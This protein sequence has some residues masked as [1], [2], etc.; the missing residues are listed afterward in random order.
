MKIL[1]AEPLAE[2]A[3][4][5]F[6]AEAGWNVVVSNPKEYASHLADCDAL[7]VRSAVKV[8]AE[9]LAQAPLLR[10]IGRAGVG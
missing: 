3:V 2:G 6:Q 5:L 1:I 9:V 8:T 7:V 4:S 10:V